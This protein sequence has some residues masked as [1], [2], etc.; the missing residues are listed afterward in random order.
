MLKTNALAAAVA[1]ALL[2]IPMKRAGA[3]EVNF[4]TVLTD[5]DGQPIKEG[6][7]VL[8]LGRAAMM[9]LTFTLPNET[10]SGDEKFKRGL[11]AQRVYTDKVVDLSVDDLAKIKDLV[12]KMMSPPVVVRAFPLLDPQAKK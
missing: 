12:G 6:D 5:M 11:L 8:T 9:A 10:I 2:A 3:V 4:G 7:K 1:F